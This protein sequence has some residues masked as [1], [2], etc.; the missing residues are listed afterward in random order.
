VW[1]LVAEKWNDIDFSFQTASIGQFHSD[2]SDSKFM[3]HTDV[4]NM[5]PAT[6]EKCEQKYQSM[7]SE[8]N[9]R[10]EK[11]ERSG[12]GDGGEQSYDEEEEEIRVPTSDGYGSLR[13]RNQGALDKVHAFFEYNQSYLI[14]LWYMIDTHGLLGSSLQRLCD[15]IGSNNGAIGVPS[16]FEIDGDEEEQSMEVTMATGTSSGQQTVLSQSISVLGK[17][18]IEAAKIEADQKEKSRISRIEA[19]KIEADQKEKSRISRMHTAS[20]EADQQEKNRIHH[21]AENLRNGIDTLKVEKRKLRLEKVDTD[22]SKVAKLI[23]LE[24]EILE[25]TMDIRKKEAEL[26]SM[27]RTPPRS[28]RTP[29]SA[30][31]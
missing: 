27:L 16:V 20:L 15:D 10:I 28:N 7:V 6:P 25:I 9:K 3:F 29:E 5:M 22:P 23:F 2:F 30:K 8:L 18:S 19:A 21:R 12:Q 26:E 13:D 4:E 11:W 17:C 14:Y 1:E 24:E 31:K